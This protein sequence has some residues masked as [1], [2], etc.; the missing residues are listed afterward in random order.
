MPKRVKK[1]TV[2][3]MAQPFL[4]AFAAQGLSANE[5]LRRLREMGLGYRRQDFLNDYR[6]Y[7]GREKAKDVAKYI[8]KDRYPTEA[9]MFPD[10]RNLKNKYQSLIHYAYQDLRTG[11]VKTKSFYIGHDR[12]LTVG[13]I[14]EIAGRLISEKA[15][16]YNVRILGY[17]YRGTRYRID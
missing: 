8:R 16:E 9:V 12:P 3:A 4:E 10:V 14:E 15:D 17:G 5:A 1:G 11:E 7:T 13:T 2:R 6:T